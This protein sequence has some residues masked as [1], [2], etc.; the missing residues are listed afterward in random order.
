MAAL[1]DEPH[2]S[3]VLP[4]RQ[5]GGRAKAREALA[6]ATA[7]RQM[8]IAAPITS[9]SAALVC[10]RPAATS[11]ALMFCQTSRHRDQTARRIALRPAEFRQWQK[12]S[13][14]RFF[15]AF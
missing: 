13:N 11:A 1:I 6:T 15:L 3:W 5:T 9:Y 12:T 8:C 14:A 10:R 4:K 7:A 2:H